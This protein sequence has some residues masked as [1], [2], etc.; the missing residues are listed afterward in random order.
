QGVWYVLTT[1]DSRGVPTEDV[2]NDR[3]F[4]G[5]TTNYVI[6]SHFGRGTQYSTLA[7]RSQTTAGNGVCGCRHY[8]GSITKNDLR[9][10]LSRINGKYHLHLSSDPNDYLLT[11]VG[12]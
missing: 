3:E 5:G 11:F 4:G 6:D 10:A 8:S 7:D 9:R 2:H 1:W 12:S